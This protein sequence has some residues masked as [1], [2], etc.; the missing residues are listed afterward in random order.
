MYGYTLVRGREEL[1][2]GVWG[3][4]RRRFPP[5]LH[6]V[7]LVFD[8]LHNIRCVTIAGLI[9]FLTISWHLTLLCLTVPLSREDIPR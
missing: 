8:C 9:F 6:S 1:P 3:T 4:G 5:S 7:L 2:D